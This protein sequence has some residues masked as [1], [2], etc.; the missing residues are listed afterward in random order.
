MAIVRF[1]GKVAAGSPVEIAAPPDEYILY[2]RSRLKGSPD[3]YFSVEIS[4][5]SMIDAGINDGDV[6]VIKNTSSP[7]SGKIMLIRYENS[8]TLKRVKIRRGKKGE[9]Q[10][11]ILW[12]DGSGEERMLDSS[13]YEIQGELYD[14]LK[15][16]AQ[17]CQ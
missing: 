7:V 6:V 15:T 2:L 1:Y 11:V 9:Q 17:I 16:S 3:D 10:V 12:E 13:E 14:N 5:S 4:G 8:S